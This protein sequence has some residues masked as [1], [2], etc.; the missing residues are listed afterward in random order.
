MFTAA[1]CSQ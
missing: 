1:A